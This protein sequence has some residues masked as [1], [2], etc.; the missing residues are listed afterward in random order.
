MANT[1]TRGT[2][3]L[4]N[5]VKAMSKRARLTGYTRFLLLELALIQGKNDCSWRKN[6][7]LRRTMGAGKNEV[8]ICLD[9]LVK[10]G[11]IAQKDRGGRIKTTVVE[12][13]VDAWVALDSTTG[14]NKDDDEEDS[15]ISAEPVEDEE[16][17]VLPVHDDSTRLGVEPEEQ[18]SEYGTLGIPLAPDPDSSPAEQM[19]V[20]L[21]N[22]VGRRAHQ[23]TQWHQC[24]SANELDK[25]STVHGFDLVRDVMLWA[26][27]VDD[28]WPSRLIGRTEPMSYFILKFADQFLPKYLG[29]K[30]AQ[31]NAFQPQQEGHTHGAT[32]SRNKDSRRD[33]DN[34]AALAQFL[35]DDQQ[36]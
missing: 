8:K 28:F 32:N 14:A 9:R 4:R 2:F 18:P 12:S 11:L 16:Q 24:E 35:A 33:S 19:A 36:S 21:Y 23:N 3:D 17:D 27:T 29:W 10:L 13:A 20:A 25:L 22:F 7:T 31:T 1:A 34:D 6:E 26:Y 5:K 30:A 15:P